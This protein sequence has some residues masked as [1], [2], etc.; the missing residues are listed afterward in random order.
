[1]AISEA[2]ALQ[3]PL[4]AAS[5]IRNLRSMGLGVY[6]D[7]YGVATAEDLTNLR[8]SSATVDFAA[9]GT[10]SEARERISAAVES[11]QEVRLPVTAR[12]GRSEAAQSLAVEFG[13][14]FAAVGAP[15][16]ADA[17]V[18]AHVVERREASS[19]RRAEGPPAV[20]L[21]GNWRGR[22]GSH[23]RDGSPAR[24]RPGCLA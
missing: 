20:H 9:A 18:T 5:F 6:L 11:A 8:V 16:P 2:D 24:G 23:L 1:M 10:S 21:R 4:T 12:H 3:D 15:I 7:H 14:A 19:E 22:R 13:C 17:F